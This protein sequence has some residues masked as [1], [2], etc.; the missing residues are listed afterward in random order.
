[1][2]MGYGFTIM[3]IMMGVSCLIL[4]YVLDSSNILN[5]IPT[6]LFFGLSL[7]FCMVSMT[8]EQEKYWNENRKNE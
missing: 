2:R 8:S 1:M 4:P 7:V 5:Y 6:I 3:T